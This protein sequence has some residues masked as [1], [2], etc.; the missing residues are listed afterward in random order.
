MICC[1]GQHL[2]CL[3]IILVVPPG[4][5]SPTSSEQRSGTLLNILQSAVL[6]M[7]KELPGSECQQ[8]KL[9]PYLTPY[10]KI[11]QNGYMT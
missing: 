10:K 9:D 1:P 3:K 2:Q 11:N 8:L 5:E 7:N 4:A 6:P